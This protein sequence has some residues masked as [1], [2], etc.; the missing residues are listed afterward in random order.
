VHEIYR[1]WRALA[2]GYDPPRIFVAEAWVASASRLADYLRQGQLHT[3]FDFDGVRTPWRAAALQQ[4]ITSSMAAHDGVGAPVTWVLSNHDIPRHVTRYGRPQIVGGLEPWRR[5][6]QAPTDVALGTRRARAAILL[7]LALPG[8][9]YLYQGEE[10][11]LPEVED[12]PEELL[13]D[14]VWERS[15]HAERGRDGCRV[16]IP[17]TRTGPSL[18]FGPG[19]GWLPQPADWP[20]LS[21]QAQEADH[22][23]MLWLYR[24]ALRIRREHP[25]LGP[26]GAAHDSA[27]PDPMWL[28]FEPDVVAFSR[29]PGFTCLVNTGPRPMPLPAGRVLLSSADLDGGRLPSDAAVWLGTGDGA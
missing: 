28:D 26:R 1:E 8:G 16:P 21:V 3:A 27:E 5:A 15:G 22:G 17:W 19:P 10:L 6:G 11:G 18:G 14:P 29:M 7:L 20:A 13:A 4:T 2:D 23:S 24:D 25:A 12:L 9:V